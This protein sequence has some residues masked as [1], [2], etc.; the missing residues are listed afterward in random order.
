[1]AGFAGHAVFPSVYTDMDN[2]KL[3]NRMVNWTYVV[4]T[5]VYFAVAACGYMMFG[6]STMHEVKPSKFV[7]KQ[8]THI[9]QI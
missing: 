8:V 6:S 3:Y 5:F 9:I 7:L 2:P 1:M 4:T